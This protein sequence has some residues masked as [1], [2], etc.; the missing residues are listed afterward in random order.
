MDEA[1][2]NKISGPVSYYY[3]NSQGHKLHIF[4]DR[5][6]K[7]NLCTIC[8]DGCML[9]QDLIKYVAD[10]AFEEEKYVDVFLEIP[11]QLEGEWDRKNHPTVLYDI[12]D[13][14]KECFRYNKSKC[15]YLPYVRFHYADIR[16]HMEHSST[17]INLISIAF[18]VRLKYMSKDI[19]PYYYILNGIKEMF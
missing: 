14:F 8:E 12:H 11:F 15:N 10:Q 5:H 18:L 13:T 1:R 2:F 9:I 16:Q 19:R 6:N 4:G 7:T 17:L 3:F